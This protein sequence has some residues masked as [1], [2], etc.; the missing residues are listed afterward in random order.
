[1]AK[2]AVCGKGPRVGNSVSHANNKTKRRFLPNLQRVRVK[3]GGTV[4]RKY[5]C[6]TCLK[7]GKVVKAA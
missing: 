6:T 3:Q 7:S 4:S 5:V 2:C 1:M